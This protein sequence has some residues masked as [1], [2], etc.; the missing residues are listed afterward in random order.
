MNWLQGL[1]HKMMTRA[2]WPEDTCR[3]NA[4]MPDTKSTAC[5]QSLHL[6]SRPPPYYQTSGISEVLGLHANV[7]PQR[8][9]ETKRLLPPPPSDDKSRR[10]RPRHHENDAIAAARDGERLVKLQQNAELSDEALE[11]AH[12]GEALAARWHVD[13]SWEWL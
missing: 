8:A 7:A 12:A 5:I 11:A 4:S 13:A 9:T 3:N 6:H 10:G 2:I 1:R